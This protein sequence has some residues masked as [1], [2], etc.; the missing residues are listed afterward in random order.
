MNPCCCREG[1]RTGRERDRER[2]RYESERGREK[3]ERRVD[4]EEGSSVSVVVII[5][6]SA[7]RPYIPVRDSNGLDKVSVR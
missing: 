7:E 5:P 6:L 4:R 1:V 3:G 2:G